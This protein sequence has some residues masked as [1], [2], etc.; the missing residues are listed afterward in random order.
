MLVHFSLTLRH[1]RQS[2]LFHYFCMDNQMYLD[3]MNL[4]VSVSNHWT[5]LIDWIVEQKI[6]GETEVFF[7]GRHTPRPYYT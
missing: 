1:P 5:R 6:T 2:P 3:Q 4:Y 7:G